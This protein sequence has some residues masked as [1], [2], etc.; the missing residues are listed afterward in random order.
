MK[1]EDNKGI[2]SYRIKWMDVAKYYGIFAIYLGHFGNDA[3]KSYIFVFTYH[4]ALF[5]FLS[6]CTS[7]LDKRNLSIM[8]SIKKRIASI[9]LPFWVFAIIS[10]IIQCIYANS[11]LNEL[12]TYLIL[13]AKGNVRN[14]FFA[15]SLWF[16]T[17]LFVMSVFFDIIKRINNKLIILIISLICLGIA[18]KG[19]PHRPIID[20]SWYY[21][22]DSMLY[23][24]I[25]YS[26]GYISFPLIYKL[27]NSPK[28]ICKYIIIFSGILSTIYTVF[29]YEGK[30]I[31]NICQNPVYINTINPVLTAFIIIWFFL[32]L[33]YYSQ[34][35]YLFNEIGKNTLY[36]CGSEFIIKLVVYCII[37]MF[38]L[39]IVLSS[40]LMTFIYTFTLLYL[41]NK[42]LVP[43]EKRLIDSIK[44]HIKI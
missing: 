23:Y 12:K 30:N 38:G 14:S 19:L 8:K 36:L 34:N 3:G 39:N 16:L 26:I 33:A 27:F 9:L 13:I 10:T 18:E 4:V 40:P 41:T 20:P 1:Y 2:G 11:D 31:L 15:L 44:N 7:S 5:F 35:I 6:G 37:S 25:F 32:V 24:L 28:K 22:I 29:L 21:N 43:Y 17:C 42:Y